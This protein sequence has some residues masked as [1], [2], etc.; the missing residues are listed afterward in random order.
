[1]AKWKRTEEQAKIYKPQKT[2]DWPNPTKNLGWKQVL[3]KGGHF[4][5]H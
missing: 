3:R 1:M 5:L 4:L 2:K